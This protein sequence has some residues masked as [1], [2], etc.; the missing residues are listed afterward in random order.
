M[1]HLDFSFGQWDHKCD[2]PKF[3]LY[4]VKGCGRIGII[5][6]LTTR[7][8]RPSIRCKFWGSKSAWYAHHRNEY[9]T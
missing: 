3:K 6:V 9:G 1:Y 2:A 8:V 7:S 4:V 5:F